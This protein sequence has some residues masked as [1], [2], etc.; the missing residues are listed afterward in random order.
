[1]PHRRKAYRNFSATYVSNDLRPLAGFRI[2][3]TLFK[4]EKYEELGRE[5]VPT[6]MLYGRVVERRISDEVFEEYYEED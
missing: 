4:L 1:M 2:G 6:V 3:V 5:F